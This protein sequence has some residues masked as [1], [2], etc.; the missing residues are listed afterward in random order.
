VL[1]MGAALR[2]GRPEEV[3]ELLSLHCEQ[4]LMRFSL[5]LYMQ[6]IRALKVARIGHRRENGNEIRPYLRPPVTRSNIV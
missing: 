3:S 6:A 1:I 5:I 4:S 2:V